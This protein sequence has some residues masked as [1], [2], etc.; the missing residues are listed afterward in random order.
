MSIEAMDWAKQ[1]RCG[2]P[3][4]K[5]VL[6]EI[7]NWTN[8]EGRAEFRV[9]RDIARVVEMSERNVQ[10]IIS[11]LETSREDGGLGLLRRVPIYGESGVQRANGFVLVGFAGRVTSCHPAPRSRRKGEGDKLSSTGAT[12]CHREGDTHVTGEGDAGVTPYQ[13][14]DLDKDNTPP[15]PLPGAERVRRPLPIAADWVC[16]PI[17]ALPAEIAALAAQWPKGAYE[18]EGVAFAQYWR[19]NGRRRAD[20]NAQWAARVQARHA[21]VTRDAKAGVI[22]GAGAFTAEDLRQAAEPVKAQKREDDRSAELRAMLE[23]VMEPADYATWLAGSALLFE[24][25]GL[26]VVARSSFSA[27]EIEKRHRREIEQALAG[28]G[29][30]VDFMRFISERTAAHGAPVGKVRSR[31]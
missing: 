2:S 3:S 27:A 24:D 31:G 18:A 14:H 20:W 13:D 22:F 25:C 5:A 11:K 9:V 1:Q 7:A 21:A 26:V 15:T 8:P 12:D 17:A 16:P 28:L 4:V 29:R 19:G 30:G 23:A 10:R 6:M